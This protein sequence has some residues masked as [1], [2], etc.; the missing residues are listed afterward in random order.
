V[1]RHTH[2][3]KEGQEAPQ[4]LAHQPTARSPTER[5][6]RLNALQPLQRR[7]TGM[8]AQVSAFMAGPTHGYGPPTAKA[9][10]D[11]VMLLN[12]RLSTLEAPA[13]VLPALV[14]SVLVLS[15]HRARSFPCTHLHPLHLAPGARGTDARPLTVRPPA[16]RTIRRH[17][18]GGR[19]GVSGRR[20]QP[21]TEPQG[22]HKFHEFPRHGAP[23]APHVCGE[24]GMPTP[25][26]RG[27]VPG[28]V[29]ACPANDALGMPVAA[30]TLPQNLG[31]PGA[32]PRQRAMAKPWRAAWSR[33]KSRS[34]G[35][36]RPG[37]RVSPTAPWPMRWASSIR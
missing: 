17:V 1:A 26:L 34:N 11:D 19:G 9:P 10:R 29:T 16:R 31:T 4:F 12:C 24:G 35:K 13:L 8:C 37:H 14:L 15:P 32:P 30:A 33:V 25:L 23:G 5:H 2:L 28:M 20:E 21:E 22:E 36:H 7:D 6:V 27:H 18:E 3:P